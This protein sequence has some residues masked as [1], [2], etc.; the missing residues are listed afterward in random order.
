MSQSNYQPKAHQHQLIPHSIAEVV[1][2]ADAARQYTIQPLAG[3]LAYNKYN[4]ILLKPKTNVSG[5]FRGMV[6][7]P[8]AR[9]ILDLQIRV[10]SV[11]KVPVFEGAGIFAFWAGIAID[12]ANATSRA[13]HSNDTIASTLSVI[14]LTVPA[15]CA[16]ALVGAV[17]FGAKAM[18]SALARY[19][20]WTGDPALGIGATLQADEIEHEFDR[21]FDGQNWWDLA[22]VMVTGR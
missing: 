22:H 14:V 18:A 6:I 1:Q 8:Q 20:T 19:G 11:G 15:V 9:A 4:P 7:N 21:M 12:F 3:N 10:P 5:N 2:G 17:P 13:M 16:R